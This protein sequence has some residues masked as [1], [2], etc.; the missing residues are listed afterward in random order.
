MKLSRIVLF[1]AAWAL[2]GPVLPQTGERGSLPPGTSQD[3]SRPADGAIK[4]G[5]ILPGE[6]SGVPAKAK[7]A[8]LA[9]SLREDCLKQ[10]REAGVGGTTESGTRDTPPSPPVTTPPQNPSPVLR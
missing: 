9:G 6:R 2:A 10:E 1:I 4:G 5:S 8:E 7:C 3:G